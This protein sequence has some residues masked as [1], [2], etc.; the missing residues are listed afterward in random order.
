M[1]YKDRGDRK[2]A[3]E[4]L[5]QVV[6]SEQGARMATARY[7]LAELLEQFGRKK[8]ALE[9]YQRAS[10]WAVV[11][12]FSNYLLHSRLQQKFKELG[13]EDLAKKEKQW[14]DEFDKAQQGQFT[15]PVGQ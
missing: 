11:R 15:I 12:D 2:R 7:Q 14:M 10:E 1:I 5:Q 6:E 3:V 9:E 4:L 8:E 13:R